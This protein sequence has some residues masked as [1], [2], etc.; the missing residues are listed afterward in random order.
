ERTREEFRDLLARAGLRLRRGGAAG[1]PGRNVGG[2]G[3]EGGRGATRGERGGGRARRTRSESHRH[4][5]GAMREHA[6]EGSR[7]CA[8]DEERRPRRSRAKVERLAVG[9][10]QDRK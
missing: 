3:E 8:A 1:G 7:R 9:L 2:G 5:P 10:G 6:A 4:P